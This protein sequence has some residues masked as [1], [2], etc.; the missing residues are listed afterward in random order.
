MNLNSIAAVSACSIP[1]NVEPRFG[2][3][4][5]AALFVGQD[6]HHDYFYF[7]LSQCAVVRYA[8]GEMLL[9]QFE[10]TAH[11]AALYDFTHDLYQLTIEGV[12]S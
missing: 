5:A 12:P 8:G 6:L 3:P 9:T 4:G 7:P 2:T 1:V 10:E 11:W